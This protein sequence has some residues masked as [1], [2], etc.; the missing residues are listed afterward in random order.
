MLLSQIRTPRLRLGQARIFIVF[1]VVSASLV[2][3]KLDENLAVKFC[4]ALYDLGE[5]IQQPAKLFFG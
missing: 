2:V 3:R 1:F 5:E 4:H